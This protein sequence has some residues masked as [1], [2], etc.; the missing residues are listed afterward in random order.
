MRNDREGQTREDFQRKSW[1]SRARVKLG[2]RGIVGLYK[3][4]VIGI[5]CLEMKIP[6]GAFWSS[7]W[8]GWLSVPRDPQLSNLLWSLL[9]KGGLWG[10]CLLGLI[11]FCL[12]GREGLTSDPSSSAISTIYSPPSSFPGLLS[13][14]NGP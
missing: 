11:M 12:L 1:R 3:S 14:A 10:Y 2:E 8:R 6:L 13:R 5:R 9:G 4:E 7:F